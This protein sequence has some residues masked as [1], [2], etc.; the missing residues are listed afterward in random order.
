MRV[1]SSNPRGITSVRWWGAAGPCLSLMVLSPP[2]ASAAGACYCVHGDKHYAGPGPAAHVLRT[3]EPVLSRFTPQLAST[4]RLPCTVPWAG[5][6][7]IKH[8]TYVSYTGAVAVTSPPWAGDGAVVGTHARIRPSGAR[9]DDGFAAAPSPSVRRT[10]TPA[11]AEGRACCR[12]SH[13]H[14]CTAV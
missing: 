4:K 12:R 14:T 3:R 1:A 7:Q 11:A 10:P 6:R 5:V 2:T 9:G 13:A 8:G